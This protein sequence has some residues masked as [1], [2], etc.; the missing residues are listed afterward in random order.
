VCFRYRPSGVEDG[1]T[2]DALNRRIL[3]DVQLGGKAFLSG[4]VLN[5]RSWLRAC[6]INPLA[7]GADLGAMV[8]AVKEACANIM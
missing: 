8:D 4:T 6:V 5:E 3:E 1:E 2:V 7:T